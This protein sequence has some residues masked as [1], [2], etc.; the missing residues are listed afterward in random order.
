MLYPHKYAFKKRGNLAGISDAHSV[1]CRN[2]EFEE[3]R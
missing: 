2:R 1:H 3:A